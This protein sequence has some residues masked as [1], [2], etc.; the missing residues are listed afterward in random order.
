[1]NSFWIPQLSGQVYTMP[2][3]VTR[4]NLQADHAGAYR[5]AS[6]NYSGAGFSDMRFNVEVVSTERF[7]RWVD[8]ARGA[9]PVLDTQAYVDLL[10]P[11]SAV[12]PMAYRSVTP[13]LFDTILHLATQ[14]PVSSPNNP[15]SRR[16]QK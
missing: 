14:P 13:G 2:N 4:L 8:A 16:A 3:M 5:G 11:S 9:G 10:K 1:M 7:D 15:A 6:A 12:A